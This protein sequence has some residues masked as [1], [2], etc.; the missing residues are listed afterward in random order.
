LMGGV[1][2]ITA[3]AHLCTARFAAL[4][5]AARDGQ[6]AEARAHAEAL[7]P[8]VLALFAEPS[9]GVL[10]GVLHAVGRLPTPAVRMPLARGSA[11]GVARALDALRG[12]S[13]VAARPGQ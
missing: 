13:V 9:P 6:V 5:A 2:G 7:L 4:L 1:G 11:D 12:A 10:K 8:V 3:S